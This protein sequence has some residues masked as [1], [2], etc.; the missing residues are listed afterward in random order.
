LK[1]CTPDT[2]LHDGLAFDRIF[3]AFLGAGPAPDQVKIPSPPV[4][5]V[6]A[7]RHGPPPVRSFFRLFRGPYQTPCRGC[8]FITI[9][10][11]PHFFRIGRLGCSVPVT[12]F[13]PLTTMMGPKQSGPI[14]FSTPGAPPSPAPSLFFDQPPLRARASFSGLFHPGRT[15]PLLPPPFENRPC[16][17]ILW[18]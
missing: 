5:L 18:F 7:F 2:H 14:F 11:D 3:F 15:V 13:S 6:W 4:I 17:S 16:L 10:T 12:I 1:D 8:P 9:V